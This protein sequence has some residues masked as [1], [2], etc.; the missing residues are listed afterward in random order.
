MRKTQNQI[1]RDGYMG[2]LHANKKIYKKYVS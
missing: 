2:E 1:K